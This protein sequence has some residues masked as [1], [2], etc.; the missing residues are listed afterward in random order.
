MDSAPENTAF[1]LFLLINPETKPDELG[2]VL[3][4]NEQSIW[5]LSLLTDIQASLVHVGLRTVMGT[6]CLVNKHAGKH[7]TYCASY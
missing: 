2:A 6:S 1:G 7:K 3:L 4:S 5:C